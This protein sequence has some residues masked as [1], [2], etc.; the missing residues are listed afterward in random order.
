MKRI[1]T[2][3]FRAVEES[4]KETE[5]GAKEKVGKK[6]FPRSKGAEYK[7]I[8]EKVTATL[9]SYFKSKGYASEEEVYDAIEKA[10]D[11]TNYRFLSSNVND[12]GSD[13][14]KGLKTKTVYS[15]EK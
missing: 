8:K 2:I 1:G 7:A 9:G 13:I 11:A 14:L 3:I 15:M 10:L 5:E 12:L 6:D 4:N